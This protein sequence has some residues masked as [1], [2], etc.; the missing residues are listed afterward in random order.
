[1]VER[2]NPRIPTRLFEIRLTHR[3]N[4]AGGA[5]ER[6][7]VAQKKD[8]FL[9]IALDGRVV[10]VE[11]IPLHHGELRVVARPLLA[12]AEARADLVNLVNADGEDFL[13]LELGGG[14]EEA[15]R[16]LR[17]ED[18]Q[19]RRGRGDADGRRHLAKAPRVEERADE[20]Q[21]RCAEAER[22]GEVHGYSNL[23]T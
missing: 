20:A 13:H 23:K 8:E 1:M 12:L 3:L 4:A 2:A 22:L 6:K 15:A 10:R 14:A 16:R 7:I 18:V 21:T 9:K 17:A 11:A 19:L 5:F